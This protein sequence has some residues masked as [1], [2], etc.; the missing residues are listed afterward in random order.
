MARASSAPA[1]VAA[2]VTLVAALTACSRPSHDATRVAAL[3]GRVDVLE[4]RLASIPASGAAL[5]SVPLDELAQRLDSGD[6]IERYRAGEEAGRRFAEA[7]PMLMQL[8]REG[9]PTQREA[10]AAVL[11]FHAG[12]DL[13]PELVTLHDANTDARVRSFL[14]LA[15][16][17]T[18]RT[19]AV[20]PLVADLGHPSER[21]RLAAVQALGSLR[22]GRA[23]LPLLR[24]ATG[25]DPV[26]GPLARQALSGMDAG[27]AAAVQA[28][29]SAL[30]PRER[31][32]ALEAIGQI[33][34]EPVQDLLVVHLQDA[35]ERVALR[36]ALEL[37]RRGSVQ[38]RD[39]AL[40]RLGSDDPVTSR[41]AREVLDAIEASPVPDAQTS[42]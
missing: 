20:E 6:V 36:A 23:T 39:L 30:N 34:G 32:R 33:P 35:S 7:R 21:V 4:K 2:A 42:H 26:A 14:D 17:R 40:A 16:G 1:G 41:A 25:G 10:A 37:A 13:A 29:W 31:E 9:T 8:L 27:A 11:A 18:G 19:E 22:D 15:L 38:G 24:V 5:A 28:Q 12:A 3:E